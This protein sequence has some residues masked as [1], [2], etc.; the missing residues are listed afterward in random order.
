MVHDASRARSQRCHRR[1][2]RPRDRG[3]DRCAFRRGGGVLQGPHHFADRRL[4]RGQR[5][6][7]LRAAAR[8]FHRQAHPRPAGGRRAEH[9]GRGQHQGGDVSARCRA[10]RRQRHRHHRT[11]RSARASPRR[12]AIRRPQLHLARQHRQQFEPVRHLARDTDP[13]LA[14][15]ADQAIRAGRRRLRFGPGQLRAHPE[16][17]R[18]ARRCGSSPAIPAAPR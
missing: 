1:C 8:T 13:D 15:R 11:Q 6:R 12:R 18:S 2:C 5:L 4:Q 7:H 16:E 9:A 3:A 17:R 14:G 10:E